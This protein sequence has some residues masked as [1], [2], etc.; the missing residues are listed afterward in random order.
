MSEIDPKELRNAFGAFMT[1][2]TVVTTATGDGVPLGFTANSFASV[3]LEPPLLLVC[4][5][6]SLSCHGVFQDRDH[7]AVNILAEGQQTVSN[8]F[9]G[10]SEDRF[11]EVDWNRSDLGNPILSGVAASFDC[12]VHQRIEAGDHTILIGEVKDFQRSD[13][14]GLGYSRHGYF[15]LAMERRASELHSRSAHVKVGAIVE[16]EG[17]VLVFKGDGGSLQLPITDADHKSGSLASIN[18]M[19]SDHGVAANIGPTYSIFENKEAGEYS[20]YYRAHAESGTTPEN[21]E[22][23]PLDP[24]LLAELADPAIKDMMSRYVNEHESYMAG[25]VFDLEGQG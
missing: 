2:V 3:S 14:D 10:P 15:D 17:E 4:P 8:L 13:A 20:I 16:F 22:Y 1:G 6:K 19:L 18:K 25:V 21:A 9:A 7:F 23:H 24:F 11:A 12:T 5:A